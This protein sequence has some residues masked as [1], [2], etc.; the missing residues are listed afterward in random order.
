MHLI[1]SECFICLHSHIP[2][3]SSKLGVCRDARF[4]E[5]VDRSCQRHC[6]LA[7]CFP[8]PHISP[9]DSTTKSNTS[10]NMIH[11]FESTEIMNINT[12]ERESKKFVLSN[13]QIIIISLPKSDSRLCPEMW[14]HTPS[15]ARTCHTKAPCRWLWEPNP[16][17]FAK[18]KK[19]QNGDAMLN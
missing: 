18:Y 3:F 11:N 16:Q 7:V 19:V 12:N 8:L 15:L 14:P 6:S 13:Q 2:L 9:S 4:Q 1:L 5:H 10:K 17:T